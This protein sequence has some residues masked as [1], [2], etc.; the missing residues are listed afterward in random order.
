MANTDYDSERSGMRYGGYGQGQAPYQGWQLQGNQYPPNQYPSNQYG[1]GQY[2]GNPSGY[3]GMYG[4]A[5]YG[6]APY[7]VPPA[8]GGHYGAEASDA[9]S[10]RVPGPY[11]GRG[12]RSYRRSDERICED[13]CD[14]LTQAGQLDASDIDVR[15][16]NAE[17]TLA[18][19]VDSRKSKRMAEDIAEGVSG[20]RD[21]HNQ[22]KVQEGLVDKAKDE[23]TP[24]GKSGQGH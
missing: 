17:V 10:W 14:R 6:Q 23:L 7:E 18:G 20:V 16:S 2:Q 4:G 8:P 13:V 9:E 5:R 11:T 19:Q 15:V 24:G 12:P 21:V 22:L 3:S 1:A